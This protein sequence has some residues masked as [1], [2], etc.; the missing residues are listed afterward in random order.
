M[1]LHFARIPW[2]GEK[3][4]TRLFK[5]APKFG[6]GKEAGVGPITNIDGSLRCAHML[7]TKGR[8]MERRQPLLSQENRKAKALTPFHHVQF[9]SFL[10][11]CSS[12]RYCRKR[13]R[14]LATNLSIPARRAAAS[15]YHAKITSVLRQTFVWQFLIHELEPRHD[16]TGLPASASAASQFHR[17][18][19]QLPPV[20]PKKIVPVAGNLAPYCIAP[21][22]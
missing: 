3:R 14:N 22:A 10:D 2:A 13:A 1:A 6:L 19:S 15:L 4:R 21:S 8:C 16:D 18:P 17:R 12:T 9:Y 5:S 11:C 7:E 20:K